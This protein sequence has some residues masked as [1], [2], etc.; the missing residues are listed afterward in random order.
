MLL[1]RPNTNF[2]W[3][4]A[5]FAIM[6]SGCDQQAAQE[7]ESKS[8]QPVSKHS[9]MAAPGPSGFGG[10]GGRRNRSAN[11]ARKKAEPKP[12]DTL[13]I[14][15]LIRL[16][17][18]NLKSNKVDA[19]KLALAEARK[20][21]DQSP[22]AKSEIAKL[23]FGAGEMKASVE[24]Y[25]EILKLQPKL[26]PE[27]WQ[28]GLALYFAEDFEA[29]VDQFDTHQGFNSQDVENSVWQLLCKSR[30]TSV[31][32]ARKTMIKIDGDNRVPMKEVFNMFA[33]T[34]TP[35]EVIEATGYDAVKLICSRESYHGWL[36]V[37]LFH[38]MMGDQEA[39]NEAMKTALKCKVDVPGL[40]GHVAEGHLRVRGAYPVEVKKRR[41]SRR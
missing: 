4:T 24:V 5:L 33:G 6:F 3:L 20:K 2:V 36:Y 10:G 16:A 37:G 14:D 41:R 18:E 17:T 21:S 40:M 32:E 19:A 38:E 28:R 34:G 1:I 35:E 26:K 30:L 12:L 31:E 23:L 29:G 22:E 11:A 9:P 15:E 39:A 13:G 8:A 7:D 25:D 27:L